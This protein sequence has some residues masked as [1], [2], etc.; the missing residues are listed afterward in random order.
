MNFYSR[1]SFV[2]FVDQVQNHLSML[3]KTVAQLEEAEKFKDEL[4]EWMKQQT[5]IVAEWKSKPVKLRVEANSAD[6]SNIQAIIP[7]IDDKRKEASDLPDNEELLKQLN[8]L[9]EFV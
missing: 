3:T 4:L 9:E 5:T 2:I 8:S 7:L 1:N 6:L